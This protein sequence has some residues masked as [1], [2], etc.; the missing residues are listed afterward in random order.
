MKIFLFLNGINKI[1]IFGILIINIICEEGG[2]EGSNP[3]TVV[4]SEIIHEIICQELNQ[5]EC[6]SNQDCKFFLQ[7]SENSCLNCSGVLSNDNQ[8]YTI[9]GG[10]CTSSTGKVNNGEKLIYNTKEIINDNCPSNYKQLGDICYP[11]EMSIPN[12]KTSDSSIYECI[13]F[14]KIQIKDNFTYYNCL[15]GDCPSGYIY[16]SYSNPKECLNSCP[17]DQQKIKIDYPNGKMALICT[18]NCSYLSE[19][20]TY[21][22]TADNNITYCYEQCPSEAKYYKTNEDDS[23]STCLTKCDNYYDQKKCV[24]SCESG[25]IIATDLT[26]NVFTCTQEC[27]TNYPYLYI[28]GSITY[29]LKSCSDT[30][31]GYFLNEIMNKTTYLFEYNATTKYCLDTLDTLVSLGITDISKFDYFIDEAALKWI[32]DCKSSPSG[33]Y[34]ENNT[35]TG[36]SVCKTSCGNKYKNNENNECIDPENCNDDYLDE[37]DK[38]CYKNC[39]QNKGFLNNGT[40]KICVS[41][42]DCEHYNSDKECS[43][44]CSYTL[45]TDSTETQF[46]YNFGDKFCFQKECKENRDHQYRKNNDNVCYNSCFEIPNITYEKDYICYEENEFDTNQ[47]LSDYIHYNNINITKYILRTTKYLECF[48]LNLTYLNNSECV[49]ECKE[50]EYKILPT[51]KEF[52]QCF[53]DYLS[54]RTKY[55]YYNNSTKIFSEKCD[56]LALVNETGNAI[57]SENLDENCVSECPLNTCEYGKYCYPTCECYTEEEPGKKKYALKCEKYFYLDSDGNKKCVQECNKTHYYLDTGECIEECP[58]NQST[59]SLVDFFS[60]EVANSPKPCL[61][62][63]PDNKPYYY[64]ND[65][66]P[67]MCLSE[68]DILYSNETYI[69]TTTCHEDEKILPG[70]KCS[71]NDCPRTAPFIIPVNYSVDSTDLECST[72]CPDNQYYNESTYIC[73]NCLGYTYNGGCYSSCP[74]GLY[75]NGTEC[76]S[77]CSYYFYNNSENKLECT[78]DNN[79]IN[80]YNYTTSSK[81]CVKKCPIGE[82]YIKDNKCL[83]SCDQFY[84][85]ITFTDDIDNSYNNYLCLSNCS[86]SNNN[87]K[88]IYG[89]KECIEE[90]DPTLYEYNNVCYKTCIN[91]PEAQFSTNN[92]TRNVCVC[93]TECLESIRSNYLN[94][95]VCIESCQNTINT[96]IDYNG[97]CVSKC[98]TTSQYKFLQQKEPGSEILQCKEK[99]NDNLNTTRYMKTNYICID[100]CEYPN[101]YVVEDE[102]YKECLNKCPE[103]KTYVREVNGEYICS[104]KQCGYNDSD[105]YKYYYMDTNICLQDCN[106]L[107]YYENNS[108]KYCVNSCDFFINKK[109]YHDVDESTD[110]TTPKK[111]CVE[112]CKNQTNDRQYSKIDGYCGTSCDSSQFYLEEEQIC[113][114]NC[115]KETLNEEQICKKCIDF[116][117][118]KFIDEDGNCVD[119]CST[120]TTGYIYHNHINETNS[121]DV[122]NYYCLNN[123]SNKKIE[124]FECVEY[125]SD[126]KPYNYENNCLEVCPFAKRFFSSNNICLDDCPIGEKYYI[127]NSTSSNTYYQCTANCKAYVPNSNSNI[128][129]TFCFAD[130]VCKD[131]YPF[132]ENGQN[133][134][135]NDIKECLAECPTNKPFYLDEITENIECFEICPNDTFHYS[136]SNICYNISK[137]ESKKLRYNNRECVEQCS[138]NEKIFQKEEFFYCIDNCT[139][140]PS[141]I[142]NVQELYLTDDN[143]CVNPCPDGSTNNDDGKCECINLFYID[144]ST[145]NKKCLN[146]SY[147]ICK[148]F[149]QYPISVINSK[150]CVSYCDGVLSI[151]GYECYPDNYTCNENNETLDTLYNGKHVCICAD[152]YYNSSNEIICLNKE[153]NC[154]TGFSYL[155][156]ET[157]ECVNSCPDEIYNITIEKTCVSSCPPLTEYNADDKKC[158]CSGKY[159]LD[160]DNMPVCLKTNCPWDYPLIIEDVNSKQCF[161]KCPDEKYL[162]YS[163]KKCV[164]DCSTYNKINSNSEGAEYAKKY[165]Q[166]KCVCNSVWYY[167]ETIDEE[168][169]S[170][171]SIDCSSL[172]NSK[173][174]LMIHSTK[175][176]VDFCPNVQFGNQ[177]FESCK[178]ASNSTNQ[179]P[180]ELDKNN[181]TC[182]CQDYYKYNEE[183]ICL[184]LDECKNGTYSIINSTKQ[185]FE[186]KGNKKCPN[187]YPVYFNGYCYKENECP[188]GNLEYNKYEQTCK[189]KYKWYIDEKSDLVCLGQERNCTNDYPYLVFSNNECRNSSNYLNLWEINYT[190]YSSCPEYTKEGNNK[191]CICDSKYYWY[192]DHTSDGKSF[193]HCG[194]SDCPEN[195][196]KDDSNKE[197]K[198]NC[199]DKFIYR[200]ICYETCPE[201]TRNGS[202]RECVLDS[203]REDLKME[204]VEKEISSNLLQLYKK[205]NT[206]SD[207]VTPSQKI[208]TKDTTVEFYGVNKNHKEKTKENLQSDLSYIDIS[209]CIDKIY[210]SNRMKED[211]DIIILKFDMYNNKAKE[212]LLI[213]PVEYKFVNSK[214][215]QEL[216]ASICQHNSIKIS[217]PLHDLISKYDNRKKKKKRNL[218]Y[219]KVELISNNKDSL[220]EKL[221]KGKEIIGKYSDIDIFNINDKLYSDICFAIEVDG[222]DL[223]LEDRINYFYPDMSLCENNCTYN[224]TDF[225]NERIYCD[226]SFKQE[227]D[228]N[229]EYSTSVEINTEKITYDQGGNININ[230]LKC[231]SNLKDAK[232]L[233]GNGGFIFMI[234]IIV[235]EVALLV[236]IIIYGIG[237]LL[238]KL[239][240]KMSNENEEDIDK[241]QLNVITNS[242]KK[243]KETQRP[244]NSPPPRK[245]KEYGMEFIPKDYIFLFFNKDEKGVI[246]KVERDA[247]PFKTNYN[248]RI[249]L[250]KKK[251]VN[252]DNLKSSGPFPAG[253]NILVIVDNMN[254]TIS[255][256]IYDDEEN[257]DK[258]NIFKNTEE[259]K[260]NNDDD[261]K[262][263]KMNKNGTS[264]NKHHLKSDKKFD[265]INEKYEPKLKKYS[266]KKIEY[267][268][269]DYDPSD[270]NYSEID[271]D[272]E[273][274][275]EKGFIESIK[276]EQRLIK[277]NYEIAS[278]NQK[279][280]NF[281]TMLFTEII[282]KIYIIKILLFTR[283]FDIL[284]F[285]FSAYFFCHTLLLIL[286]ALFF[287]I[288]TI[289]RI[290]NEDDYPGL[291][292]YLLYGFISCIII[293]IIYTIIL[294]LWSNNDKIK[295]IL[296]LI[297]A[298]KKYGVSKERRIN[299]KYSN[300]S[301]KI[302]LKIIIYSIIQFLLLAFCFV[303]FVTFCS[304]YTGTQSKVFKS[305]GIALIEVLIIKIIYGIVLAIL[306]KIS[307]VKEKKTLY[308]VILFMDTY[309]V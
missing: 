17:E 159:Y 98:N 108:K 114:F 31:N 46:L 300:L 88:Y 146:D 247:V 169:C 189:C 195:Y 77:Q 39:P 254:E 138:R 19:N 37:S 102:D 81:E 57:M 176:C 286:L 26:K 280:S 135:T 133:S 289:Q 131:D 302:K 64:N 130:D 70:K 40:Y 164:A 126:N 71:T 67:K 279:S 55:F 140:L 226:C 235:L 33:P 220:R 170:E 99:C 238:N 163:E 66:N 20:Y 198:S 6:E 42:E 308:N 147:R 54:I 296:R 117:P 253:Q 149:A 43:T 45:G 141:F 255:D 154:P 59:D 191:R 101:N 85:K 74:E 275:N 113:L 30:K 172:T 96:T 305:Y 193:L 264:K 282:D 86:D 139:A 94:D 121:D 228:F 91:N 281:L 292:F 251:D 65:V 25:K 207:S 256:Y 32:K 107:F 60:V 80:N 52:G 197:C 120:S 83:T 155:I 93:A 165:G 263:N 21:E 76:V 288:K 262:N 231:I 63:C 148:D 110:T 173:Y 112:S 210:S 171:N 161:S 103:N 144:L 105:D 284:S 297:H 301:W 229:R 62:K 270:E 84:E 271:F 106:D 230:V 240:K 128:N 239:K 111:T 116:S 143:Y 68:C 23:V 217:Y 186:N 16:F 190:L 179:G 205:S 95:K 2:T 4:S 203:V 97:A 274:N 260:I 158:E 89:T 269:S 295:D 252:Y 265:E 233:S 14:Y 47:N 212:N 136:G 194:L 41:L 53:T 36:I 174:K 196:Y 218:E 73:G 145:L 44:N 13:N 204:N 266:R 115:P 122:N 236:I 245:K 156:K 7:S 283:K 192:E 153:D 123:C 259:N 166:K 50:E 15:S 167:D 125:C 69:C 48:D 215:G 185:C 157:R 142:T 221:D 90:C 8:Y 151:S 307:L 82:I 28:N 5:T 100:K 24:D 267:S 129:A 109:L 38:T 249:L 184:T 177:C 187:D 29:C 3:S 134:E 208:V 22:Y 49:A 178:E 303:Y 188:V 241:I 34:Y 9:S 248:T 277:K 306:R 206:Y 202:N 227:F 285:Q 222:K 234:I 223:I 124:N 278:R 119:D 201:L 75:I 294:C 1:I 272:D 246:K 118:K 72:K 162:L 58:K 182:K 104:D 199:G 213:T 276:K 209:G 309:L 12:S 216:D 132:Y 211:E 299:K 257:E 304:V 214:T 175:Q 51:S 35:E 293:W 79:C 258:N 224:H 78:P 273:E 298:T 160:N 152:K 137:C 242:D 168:I 18:N 10:I 291:G 250:E 61:D 268:I 219:V 225:V 261:G 243:E 181:K 11:P 150:E 27:P 200:G 56:L 183:T 92:S 287:D 244:L 237:S 232:S 87:I 127:I 290:W 180:L